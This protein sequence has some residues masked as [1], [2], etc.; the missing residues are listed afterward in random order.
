MSSLFSK[1]SLLEAKKAH[2][3]IKRAFILMNG[4]KVFRARGLCTCRG[5]HIDNGR[6]EINV[7]QVDSSPDSLVSDDGTSSYCNG[8]YLYRRLEYVSDTLRYLKAALQVNEFTDTY[9]LAREILVD[10]LKLTM[11]KCYLTFDQNLYMNC[12]M[13]VMD[14]NTTEMVEL[15]SKMYDFCVENRI[16]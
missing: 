1:D 7:N 2:E 4:K 9:G 8:C 16:K 13:Y 15:F 11:K 12:K 5:F 6:C 14:L 3:C 10:I